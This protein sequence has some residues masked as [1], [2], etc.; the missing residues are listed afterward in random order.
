MITLTNTYEE[1]GIHYS[2]YRIYIMLWLVNYLIIFN[3]SSYH[4]ESAGPECDFESSIFWVEGNYLAA[5]PRRIWAFG[6]QAGLNKARR[7]YMKSIWP[8]PVWDGAKIYLSKKKMYLS[9]KKNVF[10][11]QRW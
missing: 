11:D 5:P 8:A 10:A 9:K 7:G 6:R 2:I 3:M 1:W 4:C